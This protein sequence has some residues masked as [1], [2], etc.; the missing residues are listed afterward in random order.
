M[1]VKISM[2]QLLRKYNNLE[3]N[4][5][6]H[7]LIDP[8]ILWHHNLFARRFLHDMIQAVFPDQLSCDPQELINFNTNG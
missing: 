2:D 5:D 3:K 4:R 1:Y 8:N 7:N 6:N